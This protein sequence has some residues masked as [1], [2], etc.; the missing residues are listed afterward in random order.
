[1]LKMFQF[2]DRNCAKCKDG[3]NQNT[4]ILA[5]IAT[6]APVERTDWFVDVD[7]E[8]GTGD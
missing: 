2:V 8:D 3:N 7:V 1:M 6:I 4:L 5:A